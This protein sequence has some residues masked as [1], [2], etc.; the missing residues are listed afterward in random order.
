MCSTLSYELFKFLAHCRT[1]IILK[2]FIYL[3]LERG[4]GRE[5]EG[6]KDWCGRETLITCF[7]HTPKLGTWLA[8]QACALTRNGTSDLSVCRMTPIPLSNSSQGRT[9]ILKA[10][11]VLKYLKLELLALFGLCPWEDNGSKGWRKWKKDNRKQT[12]SSNVCVCAYDTLLIQTFSWI[13]ITNKIMLQI[14]DKWPWVTK[15]FAPQLWIILI[16]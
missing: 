13:L 4:E 3:L 10:V 6:E 2:D 7:S 16:S 12:F 8:T 1:P 14:Q 11:L 5:R 9:L 15:V